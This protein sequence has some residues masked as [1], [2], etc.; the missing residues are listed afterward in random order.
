MPEVQ[1]KE[2]QDRICCLKNMILVVEFKDSLDSEDYEI[3]ANLNK[4]LRELEGQL[5]DY[6]NLFGN[7]QITNIKDNQHW[8]TL[9]SKGIGGSDVATILNISKYK[10]PHQLYLEKTGQVKPEQVDNEAIRKGNR[11]E[12]PMLEMFKQ[13][14]IDKY[15]VID[16]KDISLASKK[17]PYMRAN[18]DGALVEKATGRIG[19][20]EGKTT[21]IHHMN[22][23]GDW[24]NDTLPNQ[25]YCQCLHYLNVTGFDFVVVF[26]LL[27]FPWKSDLGQQETRVVLI[28]RDDVVQDLEHIEKK[29]IEFWDM[30]CN[31]KEPIFLSKKITI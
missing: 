6:N 9:R 26:A 30:V 16:T 3:L 15:D 14:Y 27:D 28:N 12:A 25:Y 31:K 5:N 1:L 4:E 18:L 20:Y 10:T 7:C 11:L 19:I 29:E 22:M 23:L 24:K 21:T 8:H 2:V 13:L 17:Y